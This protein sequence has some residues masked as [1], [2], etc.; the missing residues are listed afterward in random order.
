[1]FPQCCSPTKAC[2][3]AG[4]LMTNIAVEYFFAFLSNEKISIS[5]LYI[6]TVLCHY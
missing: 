3:F 6:K 4:L 1:M 2:F 5:L